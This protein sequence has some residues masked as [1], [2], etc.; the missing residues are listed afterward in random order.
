MLGESRQGGH[1]LLVTT[2]ESGNVIIVARNSINK[3]RNAT[4]VIL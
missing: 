1:V 4:V 2:K 3:E